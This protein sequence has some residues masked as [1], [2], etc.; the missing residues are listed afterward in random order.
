MKNTGLSIIKN[1]LTQI[2]NVVNIKP[3]S[4]KNSYELE[5]K[6]SNESN[7]NSTEVCTSKIKKLDISS[8]SFN[9]SEIRSLISKTHAYNLR[10]INLQ[11]NSHMSK[12]GWIIINQGIRASDSLIQSLN[13]LDCDLNDDKATGLLDQLNLISLRE[14]NI[15][16][17]PSLTQKG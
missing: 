4:R 6:I 13:V 5:R 14:I 17:N 3:K 12:N 2:V 11:H 15:G 9:D 16:D 8:C 7:D 1:S 10:E